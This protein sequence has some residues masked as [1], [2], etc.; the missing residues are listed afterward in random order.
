MFRCARRRR[1]LVRLL[2][3]L[4]FRV[5]SGDFAG[6][7]DDVSDAGETRG[8]VIIGRDCHRRPRDSLIAALSIADIVAGRDMSDATA[9]AEAALFV[10]LLFAYPTPSAVEQRGQLVERRDGFRADSLSARVTASG[11]W[12]NLTLL[13]PSNGMASPCLSM[14]P[15][16]VEPPVR[17]S[18]VTGGSYPL[19]RALQAESELSNPPAHLPE[20]TSAWPYLIS[21]RPTVSL[22]DNIG[23]AFR[24]YLR[25]VLALCASF[26]NGRQPGRF[27]AFP[28]RVTVISPPSTMIFARRNRVRACLL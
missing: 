27:P 1:P 4:T 20:D 19:L 25:G 10:T 11:S 7:A 8:V 28:S 13:L 15:A 24:P 9:Q 16:S 3:C 22:S 2:R 17:A 6:A 21:R 5:R 12:S 26:R 18:A 14:R 23:D